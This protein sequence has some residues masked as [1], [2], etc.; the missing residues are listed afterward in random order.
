[1]AS[2]S[3]ED[4]D[5]LRKIALAAEERGAEN[6]EVA[7]QIRTS[8][9]RLRAVA[10]WMLSAEGTSVATWIMLLVEVLMPFIMAVT[11]TS[12]APAPNSTI[13]VQCPSGEQQ[14]I[15][16]LHE[17]IARELRPDSKV[18]STPTDRRP[19]LRPEHSPDGYRRVSEHGH[20][21]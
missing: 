18:S 13:I 2:P 14:E 19:E 10:D 21:R 16:H 1:M 12:P 5:K 17:Q 9:P 8:I 20:D 15:K 6:A 4:L 7:E 3:T 11:S